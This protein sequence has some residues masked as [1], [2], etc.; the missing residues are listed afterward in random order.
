M[1]APRPPA[2]R[3]LGGGGGL[4]DAGRRQGWAAASEV[5]RGASREGRQGSRWVALGG[6]A[7]WPPAAAARPLAEESE[8]RRRVI[9]GPHDAGPDA[10]ARWR[11][12]ARSGARRGAAGRGAGSR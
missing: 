4:R 5:S 8:R 11:P 2:R 1:P 6:R 12:G 9:G 7:R 10:S 3:R